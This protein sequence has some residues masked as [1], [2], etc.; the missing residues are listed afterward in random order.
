MLSHDMQ[1]RKKER[2]NQCSQQCKQLII[3]NGSGGW[4]CK[5]NLL[6]W[7]STF[8]HYR[9]ESG[10]RTLPKAIIDHLYANKESKKWVQFKKKTECFEVPRRTSIQQNQF[11]LR[12]NHFPQLEIMC[13]TMGCQILI[14]GK[15]A[16][17]YPPPHPKNKQVKRS[18]SLPNQWY[19]QLELQSK[20]QQLKWFEP[21]SFQLVISK[22]SWGY[23]RNWKLYKNESFC[24]VATSAAQ[25]KAI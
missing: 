7:N 22:M 6:R 15:L 5:H 23:S 1:K 8:P 18:T 2:K 4:E 19:H 24:C 14:R 16:K 21:S 20:C 3:A 12:R 13:H 9:Q 10:G 11:T 17:E 25:C